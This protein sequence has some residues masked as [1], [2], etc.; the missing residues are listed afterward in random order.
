MFG[1]K[2]KIAKADELRK[3]ANELQKN[4]DRLI[5]KWIQANEGKSVN[6]QKKIDEKYIK[7]L[8][9]ADEQS[10]S[11]YK[12]YYNFVHKNFKKSEIDEAVK[13]TKNFMGKAFINKLI[14]RKK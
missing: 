3:Q 13:S 11:A 6:E 14:N 5:D 12:I 1:R 9:E 4:Q 10:N 8:D 7:L 2:R